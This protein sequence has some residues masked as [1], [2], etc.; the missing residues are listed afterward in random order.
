MLLLS[1]RSKVGAPL[2]RRTVP[3]LLASLG[4]GIPRR[5][6]PRPRPRPRLPLRRSLARA[7]SRAG[8]LYCCPRP[9]L[10]RRPAR[11]CSEAGTTFRRHRRP[12]RRIPVV[13]LAI[14]ARRHRG[15]SRAVAA[16]RVGG[17]P[18]LAI[19]VSVRAPRDGAV[20]ARPCH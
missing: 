1:Y 20:E 14:V 11:A 9:P 2:C 6:R 19:R 10:R 18:L 16:V 12:R 4:A 8:T 7:S 15:P 13:I 5:P 3:C 17:V